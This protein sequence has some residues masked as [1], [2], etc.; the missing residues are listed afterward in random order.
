[1]KVTFKRHWWFLVAAI[2]LAWATVV[3][4]QEIRRAL[5]FGAAAGGG[6]PIAFVSGGGEF[7]YLEISTHTLSSITVPADAVIFLFAG[8]LGGSVTEATGATWNTSENFTL[9]I[10]TNAAGGTEASTAAF[11]LHNPTA[12][13][14]DI[15][16]THDS[17][18]GGY[19]GAS[20]AIYTGVSRAS[21]AATYRALT[22]PDGSVGG[23]ADA[24]VAATSGD[25][26]IANAANWIGTGTLAALSHTSRFIGTSGSWGFG[27][28]D[29][30]GTVSGTTSMTWTDDHEVTHIAFAIVPE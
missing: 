18:G 26:I 16:I 8:Q 24:S 28:Q 13:T 22:V 17:D 20:Y 2:L 27:L 4:P 5:R 25:W 15:V 21:A 10:Y 29:T 11:V 12:T 30:A 14:A 23:G 3:T 6:D 9:I 19:I 1:M 7:G